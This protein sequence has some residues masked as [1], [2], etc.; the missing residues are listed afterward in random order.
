MRA[1]GTDLE[2]GDGNEDTSHDVDIPWQPAFQ[3][4]DAAFREDELVPLALQLQEDIAVA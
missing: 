4:L 1:V 2:Q 3:R